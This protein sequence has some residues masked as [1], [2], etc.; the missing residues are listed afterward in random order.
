ML[1]M[2]EES[3]PI[4]IAKQKVIANNPKKKTKCNN[5]NYL[6]NPKEGRKGRKGKQNTDRTNRKQIAR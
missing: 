1:I 5:K 6:N 4:K 3:A 2:S